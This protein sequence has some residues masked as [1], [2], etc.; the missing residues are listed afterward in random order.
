MIVDIDTQPHVFHRAV[1]K[2]FKYT[3]YLLF[4]LD[5]SLLD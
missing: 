5:C 3:I 2:L 1:D 4:A